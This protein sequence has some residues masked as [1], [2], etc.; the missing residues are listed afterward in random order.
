MS[1]CVWCEAFHTQACHVRDKSS[2][3]G[4]G[5]HDY[6]NIVSLCSSCHYH[7]FD[8]GKMGFGS[9]CEFLVV[10]RCVR[11]RKVEART[12]TT[13]IFIKDEY[14]AWKNGRV[15]SLLKAELR[16]IHRTSQ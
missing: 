11:Y 12:P 5:L 2:F 14:V 7:F 13:R 16:R 8:Q 10:L 3:V 15:H 4:G 1:R 9:G 6:H